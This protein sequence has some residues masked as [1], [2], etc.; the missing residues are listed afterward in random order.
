MERKEKGKRRLPSASLGTLGNCAR[1]AE[2]GGGRR[3]GGASLRQA[4]PLTSS[5]WRNEKGMCPPSA[6]M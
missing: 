4:H 1:R 6:P 5:E 3:D 2:E